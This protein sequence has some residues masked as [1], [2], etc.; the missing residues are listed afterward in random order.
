MGTGA[1][2]G[3][4]LYNQ[5]LY[6]G[7]T[8]SSGQVVKVS[9]LIYAAYRIAG[10]LGAPQRGLSPE[11]LQDGFDILNTLLDQW[12]AQRL[13]IFSILRTL[14]NIQAGQQ[15]YKVGLGAT[16]VAGNL[17]WNQLVRPPR[18]ENAGLY[19][20][21]GQGSQPLELPMRLMTFQ[22][23]AMLPIKATPSTFPLWAYYDYAFPYGN[24]N[25]WPVPQQSNQ[26]ALYV[27]TLASQ[28]TSANQFVVMPPGYLKALEY[29]VAYELCPRWRKPAS[30]ELISERN[31]AMGVIK[32]LNAPLLQMV[33]DPASWG[34]GMNRVWDYQTG[35]WLQR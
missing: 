8:S 29:Y 31:N 22:E 14:Q 32:S 24:F 28:F 17:V 33:C 6:G 9:G 23:W 21:S 7:S 10:I 11:E 5:G 12:N 35:D 25:V 27:W 4:T 2:P 13:T 16:D 15:T 1:L 30:A 34:T 18:I 19:L 26:I 3:N 20:V